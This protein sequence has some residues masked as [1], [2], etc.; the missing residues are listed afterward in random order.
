MRW[1]CS[2]RTWDICITPLLLPGQPDNQLS[3]IL[4]FTLKSTHCV[5]MYVY[6]NLLP[7]PTAEVQRIQEQVEPLLFE[8]QYGAWCERVAAHNAHQLRRALYP[9]T[10]T[11]ASHVIHRYNV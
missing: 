3:V 2:I 7:L 10:G 6:P 9:G 11:H 5:H 4:T 1:A 8:Q